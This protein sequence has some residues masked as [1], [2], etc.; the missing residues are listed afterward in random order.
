[1][2]GC[3]VAGGPSQRAGTPDSCGAGIAGVADR[4]TSPAG[5]ADARSTTT[6][7]AI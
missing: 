1:M 7:I 5:P 2:T 6:S 3:A 4:D